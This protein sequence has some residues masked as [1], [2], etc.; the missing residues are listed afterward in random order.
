MQDLIPNNAYTGVDLKPRER[1][2]NLQVLKWLELRGVGKSQGAVLDLEEMNEEE[3]SIWGDQ[4]LEENWLWL[5]FVFVEWMGKAEDFEDI[6][7]S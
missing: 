7:E 3:Q 1:W 4:K 2:F 6:R 5:Y